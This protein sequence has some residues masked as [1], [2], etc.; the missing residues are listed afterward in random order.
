MRS[1]P[2]RGRAGV[3]PVRPAA[4]LRPLSPATRVLTEPA[5]WQPL[6][7][8]LLVTTLWWLGA[9]AVEPVLLP[10]AWQYQVLAVTASAVVV[11]GVARGLRPS[12][13]AL[14]L[15]VGL[16]SAACVLTAVLGWSRAAVWWHDPVGAARLAGQE[17]A[18][19]VP[20]LEVSA[21]L[22]SGLLIV[23]LL[24]SWACALVSAGGADVVGLTGLV[25]AAALLVPVVVRGQEPP[26]LC[27]VGVA[28]CLTALVVTS[29]PERYWPSRSHDPGASHG[30]SAARS[31][32]C[33]VMGAVAVV[34]SIAL[35][36]AVPVVTEQVWAPV[37]AR[38]SEPELGLT[39]SR[40]LLRGPGT[41]VLSYTGDL[42]TGTSLRLPLAV[43]ADLEG[44]SWQPERSPGPTQVSRLQDSSGEGALTAGGAVARS[45]LSG[46]DLD[47]LV[48]TAGDGAGAVTALQVR[49]QDLRTDHLPVLQ[50]TALVVGAGE[51]VSTGVEESPEG[52]ES[53]PSPSPTGSG[54]GLDLD[55]DPDVEADLEADLEAWRWVEGT[56]TATGVGTTLGSGTAYTLVGWN[57]VADASGHPAAQVPVAF[58][59]SWD[60]LERYTRLPE[61]TPVAAAQAAR[62]AVAQAGAGE[63]A[64]S[65][66][67]A[68]ASWLRGEGF[69]Y[70]ESAPGGTDGTDDGS[71]GGS[72]GD[73]GEGAEGGSAMETV[74]TFL[75]ERRGYCV[76]YAS[77]FTVMARSLGL[78]TRIAVGYASAAAGPGRWTQVRGDQLHAWPEVWVEEEGWV[79]F[80]PTP[81]GSGVEADQQGQ[82]AVSAPPTSSPA[83]PTPGQPASQ[84]GTPSAAE[85]QGASA[86]QAGVRASATSA[87]RWS[88]VVVLAVLLACLLAP[89]LLRAVAGRRRRRRVSSGRDPAAAAWEELV[90]LGTDLRL[91]SRAPVGRARTQEAVAER[92]VAALSSPTRQP[93]GADPDTGDLLRRAREAVP[94]LAAGAVAERYG[95]PT[96]QEAEPAH[97][98]LGRREA[99]EGLSTASAGLRS[100]AGRWR[101]LLAVVLPASLL[102]HPDLP[103]SVLQSDRRRGAASPGRRDGD[104]D[105]RAAPTRESPEHVHGRER[106][107]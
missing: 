94:R 87:S 81:G 25:P 50:S 24:L 19:G 60:V 82:D 8:A 86:P 74:A 10:G 16:V 20:P 80:E 63:D 38:T 29:A 72:G 62:E 17:L 9:R 89:G 61:D 12:R 6:L 95:P 69:V 37:R 5:R 65:R 21:T 32:L 79:A 15:V 70:D 34:V 35:T 88:A 73:S 57:A 28:L 98:A 42:E 52:Q 31:R 46:S 40:D 43:V 66:A 3:Q 97:E 64:A 71:G 7:A 51:D 27:L 44:T 53:A 13:P 1:R 33:L 59:A 100:A 22:G 41:T 30:P 93:Q 84:P 96:R 91:L 101:R 92:L 107:E 11:P 104:T 47:H 76:H 85:A 67:A 54:A 23:C 45:G 18:T 99:D 56:S 26:R 102:P 48:G 68:L 77:A 4:R 105:R 78:P 2:G 90:A 49:V 106:M 55:A 36:G 75:Q 58:A 14:G 83:E 39:L 103:R